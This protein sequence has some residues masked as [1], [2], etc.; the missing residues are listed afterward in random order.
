M[1]T[2]AV[3]AVLMA[4]AVPSFTSLINSNRLTSQGNEIVAA[5][6]YARSE[7]IRSNRKAT[8]CPSSDGSSCSNADDWG[9]LITVVDGHVVRDATS[10]GKA[11][12][13]ANVV[14]VDFSSDGLSRD[15]DGMLSTA[16]ITV[17]ID[18]ERPPENLRV[19]SL[20]SGSRTAIRSEH[21]TCE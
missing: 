20:V 7:A 9:R 12:I 14:K 1:T 21:G 6:Q 11:K 3:M 19:I 2:I 15:S 8:L 17:C 4:I 5:L 16:E 13:S 10:S 18:A